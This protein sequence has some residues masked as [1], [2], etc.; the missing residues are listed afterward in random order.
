[1]ILMFMACILLFAGLVIDL[2]QAYRTRIQLQASADA[3]SLA[4]AARFPDAVVANSTAYDYSARRG[5]KN[6]IAGVPDIAVNVQTVCSKTLPTCV[7]ANTVVVD[8]SASVPTTFL[9]LIGIKSI[10]VKVHAT[11]CSPCNAVPLDV[12]FVL[13][14]TGSMCQDSNG[15]DDPACTDLV[16]AR[17][18]MMAFLGEMDS[19][20][21]RVGLAV[22]PPAASQGTRC[23]KPAS[24]NNYAYNSQSAPYVIVPLSSDYKAP[25][26]TGAITQQSSLVSTINCVKG[27]GGTAYATAIDKARAE[28]ETNGRANAWKVIIL[29]TDG[30]A[31]TAP[32]YYASSSSYKTQP[33][34]QGI[35]SAQI[36]KNE[37][38]LVYAIG[39][40][41]N[42]TAAGT[43]L[44][45]NA[46]TS[47]AESPT[48]TTQ[49]TL[50]QLADP[51]SFYD[52]PS[53]TDLAG[54]FTRISADIAQ[55]TSRLFDDGT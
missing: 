52:H 31:N 50:E 42:A 44:C 4:G 27:G 51:G 53:A 32:S 10:P 18:G 49:D 29:L 54:V 43:N 33:C 37:K 26:P 46:N 24:A 25:G 15:N 5:A 17:S 21:D 11:A 22:F 19:S 16:N 47:R 1:M 8:E 36:A 9:Q 45:E 2:G 38:F 41:L 48:I 35:N 3:A 12:M 13:D 40:D 30:A 55:G 34:H 6:A 7:G 14:R 23:S 28:L 20:I 39:Y